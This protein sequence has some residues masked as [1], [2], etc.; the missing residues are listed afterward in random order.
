MKARGILAALLLASS[1]AHRSADDL[2]N[3]D[4]YERKLPY[5]AKQEAQSELLDAV[6]GV[7]PASVKQS[8]AA[9]AVKLN[10]QCASIVKDLNLMGV[11][12]PLDHVVFCLVL[13][14]A[15][16]L[17]AKLLHALLSVCFGSG[18]AAPTKSQESSLA[19]QQSIQISQLLGSS[20]SIEQS[21][22]ALKKQV[23]EN[24]GHQASDAE[25]QNG[26][27]LEEIQQNILEQTRQLESIRQLESKIRHI[28]AEV[29]RLDGLVGQAYSKL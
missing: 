12:D 16:Y 28:N 18:A 5:L 13:W 7:L 15:L 14:L 27:K 17:P 9:R 4:I 6:L 26:Q 8:V 20:K 29:A 10:N 25:Q 3:F 19:V 2:D 11:P 22:A 24:S 1:H 23:A 21:V